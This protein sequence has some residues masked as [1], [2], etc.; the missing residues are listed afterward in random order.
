MNTERDKVRKRLKLK[1]LN[2]MW[3][4]DPLFPMS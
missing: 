1:Y 4:Y 2:K 3:I